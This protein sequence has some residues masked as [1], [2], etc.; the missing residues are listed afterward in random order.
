MVTSTRPN[1][2]YTEYQAQKQA[3][4]S[5]LDACLAARAAEGAA[6]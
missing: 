2:A 3:Y 1:P 4:K 6:S 5:A